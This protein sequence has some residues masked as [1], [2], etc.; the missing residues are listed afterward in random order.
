ME[1]KYKVGDQVVLKSGG[2][3]MTVDGYAWEGNYESKDT[4]ICV[5]F[6][7]EEKQSGEFNQESLNPA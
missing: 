2:P 3:T 5:W 7:G 6:V 4:V 1:K